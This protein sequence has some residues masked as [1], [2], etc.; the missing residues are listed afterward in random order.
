ME[1][2]LDSKHLRAYLSLARCGSFT[3]AARELGL[4][5][6]AISHTMRAL[7]IDVGCR[8]VEKIGKKIV[9][10]QAGEQLLF[11][12]EK[13][14]REMVSARQGLVALNSWGQLRLRV[15]APASL[16]QYVLPTV[17]REFR[18]SF[19]R[20]ALTVMEAESVDQQ[21]MLRNQRADLALGLHPADDAPIGFRPLFEDE[22]VFVVH[23]L[24]PWVQ[25]GRVDRSAI[26]RQNFILY[27]RVSGIVPM[28]YDY[29]R[30]D[31][32][33]LTAATEFSCLEAIKELLKAGLGIS[34]LPPWIVRKELAERS[35]VTLP[36]GRRKLRRRWGILLWQGRQPSS[37]EE[38]FA[39]LCQSVADLVCTARPV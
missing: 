21:E 31:G 26:V 34:I 11:H 15:A 28:V 39:G 27:H 5:Q 14:Q 22:L 19:P 4:S 1:A 16:C 29:F 23:P 3:K 7:E 35:L 13:I 12:A 6:S 32:L 33:S 38:T 9:L 30:T 25:S 2:L 24:H 8:L 17:I 36:L 20:C 10:T 18:E 37:A